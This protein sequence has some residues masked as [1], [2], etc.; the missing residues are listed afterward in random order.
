MLKDN[1]KKSIPYLKSILILFFWFSLFSMLFSRNLID[2]EES[3]KKR[4]DW[5]K[6][7]EAEATNGKISFEYS[8][9]TGIYCVNK[10]PTFKGEFVFKTKSDYVTCSCKLKKLILYI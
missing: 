9:Q 7:H 3:I 4:L 10:E 6:Q 2:D 8:P 5:I 1:T